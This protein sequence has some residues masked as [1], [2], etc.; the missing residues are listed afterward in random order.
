[1]TLVSIGILIFV[2]FI[3]NA[4]T[5]PQIAPADNAEQETVMDETQ[6]SE[7]DV[8]M[9]SDETN[10]TADEVAE[11]NDKAGTSSTLEVTGTYNGIPVGFTEDG[12]PFR[13]SPDAPIT[14]YEYSDYQCPFCRRH[15]AQTEP[16]LDEAYVQ[17][18]QVRFV[19]MDFPLEQIHPNAPIASE[20]AL[21]VADQG[22]AEFWQMH[23]LLFE[24][25]QEWSR[26]PDPN[27]FFTELAQD[28]G[29]DLIDYETCMA[30]GKTGAMVEMAFQRGRSL[31]FTGTPSF[32]FIMEETGDA[33]N[34]VGAQP[35]D[36]FAQWIDAMAAGEA[37]QG[38]ETARDDGSGN[39]GEGEIPFWATAEGLAPDPERPGMTVAGDA[40]R[41]SEDA[42]VVVIEYSDFQCPYCRRHTT[43]TQPI[44]DETFVE[45]GQVRWV[46]KHF[47]LNIH[48]QAPA[49]GVAAEC[50]GEQGQFWEM[51]HVLFEDISAW[52]SGANEAFIALAEQLDV[53]IDVFTAC[54]D[55]T[56]M[57]DRVESDFADGRPFVR[58]TPTFIV[59]A[60]GQGRIIP[61][62]LPAESFVDALQGVIDGSQ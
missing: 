39:G 47:P 46:F 55:N 22:A 36:R 40:Y 2:L 21:C 33:Y 45:T 42:P 18:G 16:A 34:L 11:E 10:E 29:V 12:Y 4:C 54:L 14:I 19:F 1:M 9:V 31:A 52:S 59:M 43:G 13:G 62:A 49:A 61:G 37:P 35:F 32:Q 30:D 48:P 15:F 44:L 25:Q 5:V 60:G 28:I 3:A 20:A 8:Q 38:A 23:A 50:A 6:E 58:G 51:H 57:L 17:S 26:L 53:D 56:E 24:T 7:T 41:G 27:T